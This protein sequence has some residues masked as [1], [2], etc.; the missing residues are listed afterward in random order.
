MNYTQAGKMGH[1][2]RPT[3]E[4]RWNLLEEIYANY[5]EVNAQQ[6]EIAKRKR[7][8]GAELLD[9]NQNKIFGI[10]FSENPS[11]TARFGDWDTYEKIEQT[12]KKFVY[13]RG[14]N[15]SSADT[16]E[17]ALSEQ[18]DNLKN[19]REEQKKRIASLEV[20][21]ASAQEEL[22]GVMDML[23]LKD[24]EIAKMKRFFLV[25]QLKNSQKLRENEEMDPEDPSAA[26]RKEIYEDMQAII[27]VNKSIEKENA[28]LRNALKAK[29]F[30]ER[31]DTSDSAAAIRRSARGPAYGEQ[32]T[33]SSRA[34]SFVSDD[35][36]TSMSH[37]GNS[38][39]TR[40]P[41]SPRRQVVGLFDAKDLQSSNKNGKQNN[42][43]ATQICDT[44]HAG[45]SQKANSGVPTD[46]LEADELK[47]DIPLEA[48]TGIQRRTSVLSRSESG[49]TTF[50]NEAADSNTFAEPEAR[51]RYIQERAPMTGLLMRL[52]AER[53]MW[54]RRLEAEI[55]NA[56][57][58]LD[59]DSYVGHAA[60]HESIQETV[61]PNVLS[62][63]KFEVGTSNQSESAIHLYSSNE[64]LDSHGMELMRDSYRGNTANP[65]N[66]AS[67]PSAGDLN[68]ANLGDGNVNDTI[69]ESKGRESSVGSAEDE[70]SLSDTS[71]QTK[72]RARRSPE[73]LDS[74][75]AAKPEIQML[76][77]ADVFEPAS[78]IESSAIL[79]SQSGKE[80]GQD[81]VSAGDICSDLN[82][83]KNV[84]LSPVST[85]DEE[86]VVTT[87][88]ETSKGAS[89]VSLWSSGDERKA[90][91][92]NENSECL[93]IGRTSTNTFIDDEQQGKKNAANEEKSE[94][95]ISLV[96]HHDAFRVVKTEMKRIRN[97]NQ[98]MR[99][100][101]D[102]YFSFMGQILSMLRERDGQ[103][104]QTI[105]A[106]SAA[107]VSG[108]AEDVIREM[109]E[110]RVFEELEKHGVAL[111]RY[112]GHPSTLSDEEWTQ[113]QLYNAIVNSAQENIAKK[114]FQRK[115]KREQ[116]REAQNAPFGRPRPKAQGFQPSPGSLHK[117]AVRI[118]EADPGAGKK[119]NNLSPGHPSKIDSTVGVPNTEM[120]SMIAPQPPP[121]R[122]WREE[123]GE[124]DETAGTP[125]GASDTPSVIRRKAW[126]DRFAAD[127]G[128]ID[129]E[130]EERYMGVNPF[131]SIGSAA[132]PHERGGR[133]H[134]DLRSR[135]L[136]L[137]R[138]T[139][140]APLGQE[141]LRGYS[142]LS[143][144]T[145]PQPKNFEGNILEYLR[146]L[147]PRKNL[148]DTE[149]MAPIVYR[150]DIQTALSKMRLE[151][152]KKVRSAAAK[153]RTPFF[154]DVFRLN[155][156][157]YATAAKSLQ[158]GHRM[159]PWMLAVI[160]QL[161]IEEEKRNQKMR[162]L[163]FGRV[164]TNLRARR[165]LNSSICRGSAFASYLIVLWEKWLDRWQ[166][167]RA[168]MR[169]EGEADLNRVLDMIAA[170]LRC[171]QRQQKEDARHLKDMKN[172]LL[173]PSSSHFREVHF[174]PKH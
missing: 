71:N 58:L 54:K 101:M 161:R 16:K 170:N 139:L 122:D 87:R 50:S 30:F 136:A 163:L 57:S 37:A 162:R 166:K 111:Q 81:R 8:M 134:T 60:N 123:A 29:D 23:R 15:V 78:F 152:Q 114:L 5:E 157:P 70:T 24:K 89:M 108:M 93:T 115:G 34:S 48:T 18:V 119:V 95:R 137:S 49:V 164:A 168:R 128:S 96:G 174:T 107:F 80:D 4:Q 126:M 55:A 11:N 20:S 28:R 131:S 138:G 65:E 83:E 109:V 67:L 88:K 149:D 144:D 36:R 35:R 53:M 40:T 125:T 105:E 151:F 82:H 150:Y 17:A 146:K 120:S 158:N 97:E 147:Q 66:E 6:Q 140:L 19:I 135:L 63:A 51:K 85:A 27:A 72:K 46:G 73:A 44:G 3:E 86:V 165:L 117:A 169:Q 159:T 64:S 77:H 116:N 124:N 92:V 171:R 52:H 41:G 112:S 172:P 47:G 74:E 33:N 130:D 76:Q 154:E 113:N 84:V 99:S 127:N 31:V 90:K 98:F 103:V 155:I 26:K 9:G 100:E 42:N 79:L 7:E 94:T 102:K 61:S 133:R 43:T 118:T 91:P 2:K 156:L 173:D 1:W 38:P 12:L 141:G 129:E 110:Q 142:G 10:L 62:L 68:A 22:A 56:M 160:R 39:L 143:R 14:Q 25:K 145:V 153:L 69:E 132:F 75:S 13:T 148:G 32:K 106:E 167:K 21:L 45:S 59:Y 104:E 121:K